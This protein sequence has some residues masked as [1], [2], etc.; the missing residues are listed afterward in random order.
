MSMLHLAVQSE[1]I[2]SDI[3]SAFA[4]VPSQR[5]QLSYIVI[6]KAAMFGGAE[7]D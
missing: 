5:Y 4:H 7:W 6:L 3:S 1:G 2:T